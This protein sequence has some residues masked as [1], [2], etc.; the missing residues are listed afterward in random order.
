MG[1]QQA[2]PK[3]ER[4]K[5]Q[6][7]LLNGEVQAM[8]EFPIKPATESELDR[9]IRYAEA[10]VDIKFEN[11][12]ILGVSF[13]RKV[14][15]ASLPF[16]GNSKQYAFRTALAACEFYNRYVKAKYG[17]HAILCEWRSVVRKY[18]LNEED[19]YQCA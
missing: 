9:Y 7:R 16:S 5:K 11:D 12:G 15:F 2:R 4:L 18:I 19:E 10:L 17:E 8:D 14:Y 13:K 6:A 3:K 1:L